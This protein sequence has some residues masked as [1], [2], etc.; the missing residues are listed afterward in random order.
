M[1]VNKLKARFMSEMAIGMLLSVFT[2][3]VVSIMLASLVLILPTPAKAGVGMKR[4]AGVLL[5]KAQVR[6]GL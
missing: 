3:L 1:P 2:G 6:H 5:T 4:G